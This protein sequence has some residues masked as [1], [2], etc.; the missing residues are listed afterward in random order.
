MLLGITLIFVTAL[1]LF[2]KEVVY[3]Y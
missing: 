1:L 2:E 3:L